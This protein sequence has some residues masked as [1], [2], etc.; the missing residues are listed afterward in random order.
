MLRYLFLG[1]S[2]LKGILRFTAIKV[3]ETHVLNPP[4][5][6]PSVSPYLL[7]ILFLGS[8]L[9]VHFQLLHLLFAILSSVFSK[10]HILVD[11]FE[12]TFTSEVVLFFF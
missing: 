10:A 11:V 3:E 7:A 4:T 9:I 12:I 6:L 1:L 2:D 5:F 8:L